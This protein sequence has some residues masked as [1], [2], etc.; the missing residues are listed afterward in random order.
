M[1]INVFPLLAVSVLILAALALPAAATQHLP[2]MLMDK[3]GEEINPMTGDNADRP[4]STEMTCGS[5][6]DYEEITSG[7]H[8]QMGWDVAADDFGAQYGRPWDISNGFMGRWY[9]YAFRQLARKSNE[10]ADE[11]DLTV[12]DFIGFSAPGPGQLP[13]GACHPGGGG[14]QYDRDGERYDVTLADSPELAEELDGDYYRSRWDKSGVVEA[15]CFIC[16]LKG[17]NF[18]D[19]VSQLEQGNYQWA[20]VAGSRFGIVNGSVKRG[21]EPTVRYN[22]RLFNEDGT[23]S[24]DVSWPPPDENC[25]YCHGQSDMGKR[26]F[27]WNDVHNPDVHN[28]QGVSCTSCHPAGP[29]HQLARGNDNVNRVAPS[30]AIR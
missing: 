16:H 1:R 11:I 24:L 23:L 17:Y 9:P 4:F 14:L 27:S 2:I 22:R 5:C 29:D 20:V 13:C 7:F 6:H 19:R 18:D 10:S 25:E 12:Y 15:D 21:D 26:G 8:F 3:D 30:S 28:Q